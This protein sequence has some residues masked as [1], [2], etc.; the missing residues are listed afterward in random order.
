M[1][2]IWNGFKGLSQSPWLLRCRFSIWRPRSKSW[3][4]RNFT[5]RFYFKLF[6]MVGLSLKNQ[7]SNNPVILSVG[8][9]QLDYWLQILVTFEKNNIHLIANSRF[10]LRGTCK[11]FSYKV[12]NIIYCMIRIWF[13]PLINYIF[14][15]IS[16]WNKGLKCF[17]WNTSRGRRQDLLTS[18]VKRTKKRNNLDSESKSVHQMLVIRI[19]LT[20]CF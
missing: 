19:V 14:G 18:Q 13:E 11:N 4:A 15:V 1:C 2:S 5:L 10:K 20:V 16:W 12:D 7:T 3:L 9:C 17:G 6:Q 8:S